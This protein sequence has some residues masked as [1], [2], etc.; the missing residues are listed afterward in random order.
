MDPRKPFDT[1]IYTEEAGV[2]K[3]TLKGFDAFRQ[4]NYSTSIGNNNLW[5]F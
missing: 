4:Y 5:D 2:V 1:L 3:D